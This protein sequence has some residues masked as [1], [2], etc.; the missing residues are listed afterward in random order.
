MHICLLPTEILLHIFVIYKN[1][2]RPCATLA[3]LAATC[4]KFK[5][6]ALDTLWKDITGFRP[7]I[8]CLLSGITRKRRGKSVLRRPFSDGEWRL[9]NQYA[10]RI[11]SF[12]V[13]DVELDVL[14]NQFMQALLSAP[15]STPLLPNLRSLVWDD[16]RERFHPLLRA[17]LGPTITFLELGNISSPSSLALLAFLGAQCPSLRELTCNL[18]LYD[19]NT[20]GRLDASCE[21]L[22]NLRGLS[23]L[24]AGYLT[25]RELLRLASLSSLKSLSFVLE[26]YNYEEE[27][28]PTPTVFSKLDQV[29]ITAEISPLNSCLAMSVFCPV[30]R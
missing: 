29:H 5:E 11:R 24:N 14:G 10:R 2:Y 26:D 21:A 12:T 19:Y 8:S 23:R 25:P 15:L 28:Y 9:I 1:S 6:P 22:H 13:S 16:T 20:E 3:A 17:L 4:R 18:N 27:H 7:L 30:D